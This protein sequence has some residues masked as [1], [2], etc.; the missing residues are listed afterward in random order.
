MRDQLDLAARVGF[1]E[2]GVYADL[3]I[4]DGNPLD[5]IWLLSDPE[6]NLTAIMKDG[7]V[8]ENTLN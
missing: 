7:K 8:F 4:V 3:L 6:G 1:V 2:P 5:D